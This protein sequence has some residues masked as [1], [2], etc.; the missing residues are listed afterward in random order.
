MRHLSENPDIKYRSE[1]LPFVKEECKQ[2]QS[3][4]KIQERKIMRESRPNP[5]SK[6][7]ESY[8]KWNSKHIYRNRIMNRRPAYE[9][10]KCEQIEAFN[11]FLCFFWGAE[12]KEDDKQCQA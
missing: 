1:G 3:I 2:K 5:S 6:K 11:C 7:T 9:Q 4:K 12:N 10:T 8:L